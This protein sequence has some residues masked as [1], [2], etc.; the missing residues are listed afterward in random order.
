MKCKIVKAKFFHPIGTFGTC[1]F[2]GKGDIENVEII[3]KEWE[4]EIGAYRCKKCKKI[5]HK[6]S[7]IIKIK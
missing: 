4:I 2:C 6:L 1:R 3:S 5:K 7:S